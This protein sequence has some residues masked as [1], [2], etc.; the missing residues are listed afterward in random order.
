[1]GEILK[2]LEIIN[3]KDVHGKSEKLIGFR[4]TIG[5]DKGK[6]HLIYKT[7]IDEMKTK[8][9]IRKPGLARLFDYESDVDVFLV[10]M[11]DATCFLF[12]LG[13]I[14][15]DVEGGVSSFQDDF[16]S[17]HDLDGSIGI[18]F[19]GLEGIMILVVKGLLN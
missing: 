3:R 7:R 5:F 15:T 18:D 10:G 4:P 14:G 16:V 11:N 19:Q 6:E 2:T 1:M 17:S 13:F 12:C 9:T 8:K